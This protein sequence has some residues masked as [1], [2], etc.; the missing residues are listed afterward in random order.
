MAESDF[1]KKP[2]I[3]DDAYAKTSL[4]VR[5]SN[6]IYLSKTKSINAKYVSPF[7]IKYVHQGS[8][9]YLIN[10]TAR[11]VESG[12][13]LVNNPGSEVELTA[14]SRKNK[15]D[16]NVGMS[17]FISS[18]VMQEIYCVGHNAGDLPLG[19]HSFD[20]ASPLF[21]EDVIRHD[22]EPVNKQYPVNR[23]SR[24]SVGCLEKCN[25]YEHF[26]FYL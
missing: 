26:C 12:S 8:D 21:Y 15:V 16:Y 13:V 25:F 20:Q 6:E 4:P 9:L 18:D 7:S 11:K 23:V 17:I 5:F 2:V 19:H 14:D 24:S 22:S 1:R 3:L 10:G